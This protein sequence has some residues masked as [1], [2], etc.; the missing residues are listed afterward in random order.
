MAG[1]AHEYAARLV[2]TGN[3]GDGT[4]NYRSYE[5]SYSV[6]VEGKPELLGTADPTFRGEADKYNPEDLFLTAISGCHMLSYLSLCARR[7]VRV[8][9]YEDD[10]RG[11][12]VLDANG[13]GRFEEVSLNPTVTIDTDDAEAVQLAV[14]LHET[15]HEQ[16]FIANSCSV[17]IRHSATIHTTSGV[18]A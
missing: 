6:H 1:K 4:A 17:P 14:R 11:T 18:Q 15:A 5:R 13:G 16:C 10:A 3:T 7:G 12:L 2:W 9:S 8:V